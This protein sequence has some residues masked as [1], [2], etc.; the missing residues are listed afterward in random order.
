[1][2]LLP[3]ISGPVR[4]VCLT[5]AGGLRSAGVLSWRLWCFD[6]RERIVCRI[7]VHNGVL[8]LLGGRPVWLNLDLTCRVSTCNARM[9]ICS[10]EGNPCAFSA[11]IAIFD[12][13][14]T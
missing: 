4:D 14:R 9:D 2:L 5:K 3:E 10:V 11:E 7:V 12:G 1:M 13:A 6:T 8:L